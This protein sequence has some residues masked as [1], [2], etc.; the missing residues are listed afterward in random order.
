MTRAAKNSIL[1]GHYQNTGC[2]MPE[3]LVDHMATKRVALDAITDEDFLDAAATAQF[4]VA[5][6]N[7][8]HEEEKREYDERPDFRKIASRTSEEKHSDGYELPDDVSFTSEYEV[9]RSDG[10]VDYFAV[11][12]LV[13]ERDQRKAPAEGV[14]YN[15][16]EREKRRKVLEE[17]RKEAGVRKRPVGS[18]GEVK[19]WVRK[20]DKRVFCAK[21][22]LLA[23]CKEDA[24]REQRR[25]LKGARALGRICFVMDRESASGR[26]YKYIVTEFLGDK[27]LEALL[28]PG[29]A[30][31][32]GVYRSPLQVLA[33]RGQILTDV[34]VQMSRLHANNLVHRD[35]KAANILVDSE[36]RGHIV[37]F[38]LIEAYGTE[39]TSSGTPSI[40]SQDQKDKRA[41]TFG[42]DHYAMLQVIKRLYTKEINGYLGL[43][44]DARQAQSYLERQT[45]DVAPGRAGTPARPARGG[46]GG[47]EAR[48]TSVEER[49]ADVRVRRKKG[50]DSSLESKGPGR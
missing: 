7:A 13:R 34:L 48:G 17:Q 28:F 47:P 45:L 39:G 25:E 14:D 23:L 50:G 19:R 42:M 40:M 31:D 41:S 26:P 20:R 44:H 2:W 37:D 5:R 27:D 16:E 4:Q 32:R 22:L 46:A 12:G 35:I 6:A 30:S 24:Q 43:A 11:Q 33:N 29:G 3:A 15:I 38:G 1:Q 10:E 49:K 18:Y 36:G 9:A 8:F 21:R